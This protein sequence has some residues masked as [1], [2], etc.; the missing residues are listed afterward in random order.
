MGLSGSVIVA[1][2][3]GHSKFVNEYGWNYQTPIKVLQRRARVI[4]LKRFYLKLW[5]YMKNCEG[6][7]KSGQ[8]GGKICLT[9]R[10]GCK[11]Q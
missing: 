11:S 10:S 4:D 7:S 2:A 3:H 6:R 9:E 8:T 5:L 1:S